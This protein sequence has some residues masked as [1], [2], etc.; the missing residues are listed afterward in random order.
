MRAAS[1][2]AAAPWPRL[3]PLLADFW[4]DVC[5][6]VERRHR[7][8]R[9]KQWLNYLRLAYPEAQ[10]A[11]D[12]LRAVNDADAIGAWVLRIQ[13]LPALDGRGLVADLAL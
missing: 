7:A 3:V 4:S 1:A 6:R 11:F 2:V 8:G 13:E 10:Q 12:A 5:S 9:L